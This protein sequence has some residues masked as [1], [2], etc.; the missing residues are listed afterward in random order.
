MWTPK[1]RAV[2][3]AA[4]ELFYAHGIQAIGVDAIAERAGVTK[5]TLYDRFGSKDRLVAEYL[6]ARDR[7]WW[8]FLAARLQATE[9]GPAERL[10]AVFAA[11]AEWAGERGGRGCAMIN[12]YAE[13]PTPD[14]PASAVI[15][16]QKQKLL[17]LFTEIATDAGVA[18]PDDIGAEIMMLHEG[19]IVADGMGVLTGAFERAGRRAQAILVSGS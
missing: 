11:S 1:A 19:A 8:D 10:A 14:H 2:L 16:G 12:A 9:P 4:N 13:I 18:D 17:R 5:K 6:A 7:N 15:A 3:A